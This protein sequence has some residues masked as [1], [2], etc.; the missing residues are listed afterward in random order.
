EEFE[1]TIDSIFNTINGFTLLHVLFK[2]YK[3]IPRKYAEVNRLITAPYS[4]LIFPVKLL[5]EVGLPN[6]DFY[7]YSDDIDF[8]L[9]IT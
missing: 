2:N 3:M 8:T 7:L 5:D 9:R 1:K 4:G 6:K